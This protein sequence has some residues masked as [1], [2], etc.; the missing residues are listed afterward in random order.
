MSFD[1]FFRAPGFG[2]NTAEGYHDFATAGS[3]VEGTYATLDTATRL[4][5]WTGTLLYNGANILSYGGPRLRMGIIAARLAISILLGE[6]AFRTPNNQN[7]V[8]F[9]RNLKILMLSLLL[10]AGVELIPG[11]QQY[12]TVT[13][14]AITAVR[15]LKF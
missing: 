4:K 7:E 10:R 11:S 3:T 15:G 14:L 9:T 2:F 6:N 1:V 5:A 12:L 8:Y 13:D